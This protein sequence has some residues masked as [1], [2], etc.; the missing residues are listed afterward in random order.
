MAIPHSLGPGTGRWRT[1]SCVVNPHF[2][3]AA[4]DLLRATRH[5]DSRARNEEHLCSIPAPACLISPFKG[6]GEQYLLGEK[7][8]DIGLYLFYVL[9]LKEEKRLHFRAGS[10]KAQ[11]LQYARR[12]QP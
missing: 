7:V 9:V 10:L 12:T 2:P 1:E 4:G 6:R 3:V 8:E 11:C 5:E